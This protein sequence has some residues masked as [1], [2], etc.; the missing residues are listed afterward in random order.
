M[1]QLLL[2]FLIHFFF[3]QVTGRRLVQLIPT[4]RTCSNL[5]LSTAAPR[6]LLLFRGVT[7]VWVTI[8]TSYWFRVAHTLE[9]QCINLSWHGHGHELRACRGDRADLPII[10]VILM[11]EVCSEVEC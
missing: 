10:R 5:K 11:A 3:V 2:V 4:D 7:T 8:T 6:G 9:S 1:F